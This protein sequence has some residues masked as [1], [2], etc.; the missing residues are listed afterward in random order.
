MATE[1]MTS[2]DILTTNIPAD[3][4]SALLKVSSLLAS[5]LDLPEVLQIAITSAIDL[6]G[7]D[8]GAIYT[9]ENGSLFL[10]ATTPPLPVE[11][12]DELRAANLVN[13]PHIEVVFTTRQPVF[14]HDART[15]PLTEA[16]KIVVDSRHLVSLLYFPLLLKDQPIGTFIIGTT[17]EVHSFSVDEI[18][19]ASILSYQVASAIANARLYQETQN[20]FQALTR[21]YHDTLLGW[22][23]MLN[24]KD[25]VTETHTQ[26]V[27]DLTVRLARKLGVPDEELENVRRGA[28]L[29]DIGKIG[30]PDTVLQKH[31]SLTEDEWVIMKTHPE[32]AHRVLSK[33]DYLVDALDIP[34][35]HHEKWDGTGYP[36]GLKGEEIPIAA[37][38]FAVVD[39]YDALTTDR[40]YRKAWPAHEAIAYLQQES[41]KHF[42][43]AAVEAFLEIIGK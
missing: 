37:L 31:G 26:R 1:S 29:H 2:F 13:H 5:T 18:N 12:P 27:M 10:G 25:D 43:P 42:Y 19:L 36:R 35:C 38:L 22:S 11:F 16:E 17:Q 3:R 34:Y 4:V 33:I 21:A 30:I 23:N 7:L 32:N 14:I 39:V 40:P 15:V 20:S 9:L 41:G 24:L 28:L 8:S 6:L